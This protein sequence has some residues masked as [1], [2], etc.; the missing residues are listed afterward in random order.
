MIHAIATVFAVYASVRLYEYY[1]KTGKDSLR[2]K[3]LKET[4]S[5]NALKTSGNILIET[6][7]NK[8]NKH[9]LAMSG[10]SIGLSTAR[11]FYPPLTIASILVFTYTAIPYLRLTEKSLLKDKKVDGYVLYS[12]ADLMMLGLGALASASVGIT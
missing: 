1:K 12:I 8:K 5:S 4:A 10:V 9:Y 3:E 7:E 11:I 2:D 6:D